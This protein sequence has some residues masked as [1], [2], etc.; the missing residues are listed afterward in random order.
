MG[1]C[2]YYLKAKFPKGVLNKEKRNEIKVF[3]K[4]AQEFENDYW[5][6]DWFGQREMKPDE[7][8]R[9]W[10]RI[11]EQYPLVSD[12]IKFS[13]KFETDDLGE[14]FHFG[15]SDNMHFNDTEFWYA[16]EVSHSADWTPMA[17]YLKHEFGASKVIWDSE[18]NGT[19]SFEHLQFYEYKEIVQALMKKK[20]M[21]PLL[22][23][24]HKDLD[25]LIDEHLRG[26]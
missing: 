17:K 24:V 14:I 9:V 26:M 15:T 23:H 6:E 8:A 18:E 13:G 2:C 25:E 20:E 4:E 11:E 22:L 19:G 5:R 7:T 10:K 12:Y 16:D 21:F 1:E 3:W